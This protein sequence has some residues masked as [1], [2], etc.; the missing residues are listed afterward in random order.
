MYTVSGWLSLHLS[1]S[2]AVSPLP[3]NHKAHAQKSGQTV[4][5][6]LQNT[7]FKLQATTIRYTQTYCPTIQHGNAIF[8]WSRHCPRTCPLHITAHSW[9]VIAR[10]LV[11]TLQ[12]FSSNSDRWDILPDHPRP[13]SHLLPVTSWPENL[14]SSRYG[15]RICRECIPAQNWSSSHYSPRI[16]LFLRPNK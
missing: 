1:C 7:S 16:R 9:H 12:S 14:S 11:F 13:Q 2:K 8:H 5:H 15:P 4:H 3:V 10:E 6:G